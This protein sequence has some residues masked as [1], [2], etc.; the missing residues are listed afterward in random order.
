MEGRLIK[1][2]EL[3]KVYVKYLRPKERSVFTKGLGY[4]KNSSFVTSIKNTKP[5]VFTVGETNYI[6]DF[7]KA[8]GGYDKLVESI[9]YLETCK[10]LMEANS[11]LNVPI[12]SFYETPSKASADTPIKEI[13]H[14]MSDI[15][16]DI[17]MLDDAESLNA[18]LILLKSTI[19]LVDYVKC[20][21]G[22]GDK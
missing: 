19:S 18:V 13:R 4:S 16:K 1:A 2:E 12:E 17:I 3:H 20:I 9:K 7:F 8:Y 21:N 14:K 10:G 5:R 6:Y 22:L 15:A 11:T